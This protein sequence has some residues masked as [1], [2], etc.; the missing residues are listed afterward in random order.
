MRIDLPSGAWVDVKDNTVPGDRFAVQDSVDVVVEDGRTVIHGA[1]SSQWKAYLSRVVLAWSYSEKG[2]PLPS[3]NI[4]VLDEY[5]DQE[6]D[7]DALEDA[8]QAR[9]DRIVRRRPTTQ[10]QPSPTNG[11]S[12]GS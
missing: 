2:V 7:A 6:E 4:A 5:P 11:T 1:A 9:Y 10:R 8:L 3:Q 12:T